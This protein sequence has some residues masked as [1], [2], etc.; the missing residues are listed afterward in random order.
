MDSNLGLSKIS[1]F[2]FGKINFGHEREESEG[3]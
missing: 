1:F 2:L 3:S